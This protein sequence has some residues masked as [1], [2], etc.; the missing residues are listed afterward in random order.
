[1]NHAVFTMAVVTCLAYQASTSAKIQ[2]RHEPLK[3]RTKYPLRTS[4]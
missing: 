1:M 4:R 2:A 3:S